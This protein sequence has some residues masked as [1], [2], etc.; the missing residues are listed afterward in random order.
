MPIVNGEGPLEDPIPP[1]AVRNSSDPMLSARFMEF[2]GAGLM[3]PLAPTAISDR[4]DGGRGIAILLLT[5]EVGVGIC[6]PWLL[7]R[8]AEAG[9]ELL[10]SPNSEKM[11]P[12]SAYL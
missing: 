8:F 3:R 2:M 4:R 6:R 11:S 10:T 1:I 7:A 5:A 12:K 9:A